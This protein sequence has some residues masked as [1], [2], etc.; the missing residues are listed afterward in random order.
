MNTILNKKILIRKD[1]NMPENIERAVL[2]ALISAMYA[3]FTVFLMQML[4][5]NRTIQVLLIFLFLFL[6]I[7]VIIELFKSK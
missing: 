7:L 3:I 2:C 1:F 6:G 4:I 5:E